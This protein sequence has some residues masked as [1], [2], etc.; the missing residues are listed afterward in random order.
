MDA[1]GVNLSSNMAKSLGATV[2]VKNKH[3]CFITHNGGNS[4]QML[5]NAVADMIG[6]GKLSSCLVS[7]KTFI[8]HG[9]WAR[10][11]LH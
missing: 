4:A 11:I 8:L 9:W 3:K 2:G 1:V 5:V 7:G 10:R 6:E